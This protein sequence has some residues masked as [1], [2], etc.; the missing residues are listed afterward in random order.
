M[1][2]ELPEPGAGLPQDRHRCEAELSRR[3]FAAA[4]KL[5]LLIEHMEILGWRTDE[6][7]PKP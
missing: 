4:G 3:A 5:R 6:Y 1:A 2:D 7:T